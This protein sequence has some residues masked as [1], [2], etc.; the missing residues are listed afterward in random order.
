MT[1]VYFEMKF[2]SKFGFAKYFHEKCISNAIHDIFGM[3]EYGPNVY[4]FQVRK[5]WH[6]ITQHLLEQLR[7]F[8]SNL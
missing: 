4:D 6:H 2:I 7:A 8:E 5:E 1:L 3:I